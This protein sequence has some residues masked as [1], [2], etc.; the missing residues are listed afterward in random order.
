[1]FEVSMK[2]T[3]S[4]SMFK[5]KQ[6]FGDIIQRIKVYVMD[7]LFRVK[8]SSKILFNY[9]STFKDI[10]L[11]AGKGVVAF[12]NIHAFIAYAYSS[13][14][15][16]MV[17]SSMF[18]CFELCGRGPR[19]SILPLSTFFFKFFR[20]FFSKTPRLVPFFKFGFWGGVVSFYESTLGIAH[21]MLL[22]IKKASPNATCKKRLSFK[23]IRR[24]LKIDIKNPFPAST[25]IVPHFRKIA[26]GGLNYAA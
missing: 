12:E 10:S 21:D 17:S 11:L 7:Y 9:K 8:V 4:V 6:I 1:M 22:K 18:S 15:A 23:A 20:E 16:R 19:F 2:N 26:T 13:L 14:P 25:Y 3:M 24:S 5:Y